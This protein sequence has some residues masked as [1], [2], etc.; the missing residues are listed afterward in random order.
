VLKVL[1]LLFTEG[2]SPG[3]GERVIRADICAEAVRLAEAVAAHPLVSTPECHALA[4][5]LLFQGARLAARED[6]HGDILLLEHQDRSTWNGEWIARGFRHLER[7][8]GGERLTSYHLEAGIAACHA[9]APSWE[10]TDWSTI[11]GYYDRLLELQPSPVTALNRAV[12]LAMVGGPERGLEGIAGI[13]D[14]DALRDYPLLDSV[15]G[16]LCRRAGRREEARTHFESA[17]A[18]A[19]TRPEKRFLEGR[20]RS[21]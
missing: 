9:A 18:R 7:S 1:Y 14:D 6:E 15:R 19:G 16:E 5:L 3:A 13:A 8:M 2:Y 4:A 10:A 17:L 12:A 11:V 21:L 20:L